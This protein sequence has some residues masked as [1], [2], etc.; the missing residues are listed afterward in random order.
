MK[1]ADELF[2]LGRKR[3][4][5]TERGKALILIGPPKS[6]SQSK[7]D[8]TQPG[9]SSRP[10]AAQGVPM[11]GNAGATVIVTQFI[12]EKA[13][14]PPWA[15]MQALDLKFQVDVSMASEQFLEGLGSAKR[16]EA[17]AAAGRRS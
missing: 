17:K 16:L 14:L 1:K 6:I 11:L 13:Q 15:E 4:A 3:G 5:L 2:L 8:S 7:D 9:A 12:Y 10:G